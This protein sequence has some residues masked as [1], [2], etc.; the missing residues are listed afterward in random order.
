MQEGAE[1]GELGDHVAA[2]AQAHHSRA[3]FRPSGGRKVLKHAGVLQHEGDL[4]TS[5]RQAGCVRHLRGEHLEVEAQAI[6]GKITDV[7]PD[8]GIGDEIPPRGEAVLRVL[9][10]VQLHARAANK[11]ITRKPVELRPHVVGAKVGVGDDRMWPSRPVRRPLNP[12]GLVLIGLRGPVGL[13]VDRLGDA[14]AGD[15]GKELLDRIVAPDGFVGTENARLHRPREP[16]QVGL[17]PDVVMAVDHRS[18][19]ALRRP[20][21]RI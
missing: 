21:A 9:M 11:R 7:A 19:A 8:P 12:G 10:P 17:P 13:H 3:P 14:G 6:V 20:S 5:L 18:H 1:P 2:G 16:R 4:R 15:V